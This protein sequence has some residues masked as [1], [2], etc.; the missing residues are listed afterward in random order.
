MELQKDR[1]HG[2]TPGLSKDYSAR[3]AKQQAAFILPYLKS[4]MNLL[5]IGCGPGTITIGFA[6]WVKP[7]Y[8]A[9]IDHDKTNVETAGK[10]ASEKKITNAVFQEGDALSLPFEDNSFDAAFENN[11]FVHLSNNAV[12]SA[13][14]IF[15]VLKTGGLFAARDAD[16]DSVVWGNQNEPLKEFDKIFYAWQQS[17]GSEIT[18][19]KKLPAIL[20]E[21]GFINTIKS[22]S[23]DTKGNPE[24]VKSHAGIMISLLDGPLKK[25]IIENKLGD[26]SFIDHLK[27][28]IIKWGEHPDSFFA[29]V[30]VEVIGWKPE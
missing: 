10:L 20:R 3:K 11:L 24:S 25:Y 6:D 13:T 27:E 4:G 16:S 1:A 29:N 2:V 15:R 5:D 7:G 19:G 9:G 28:N 8:V 22:V 30:H 18:I 14:E 21:A 12:R 26:S 23:A 17:R